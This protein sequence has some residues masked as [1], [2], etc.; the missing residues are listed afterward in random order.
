[1]MRSIGIP[2]RVAVGFTP[3]TDDGTGT[4][5]VRG[6]NAHAWPEVWFD[7][8]GWV[9][10]EPTPD[11]GAPGAED[12][13]GVAPQQAEGPIG[14]GES[15]GEGP[16]P[17]TTLPPQTTIAPDAGAVTPTTLA[18]D[19]P[20]PDRPPQTPDDGSVVPPT[21]AGFE[22]PW[23]V[24]LVLALI[25]SALVLPALIRRIRRSALSSPR[26][27]LAHLWIRALDAL[28]AMGLDASDARTPSETADVAG[29]IFP[30]ASR[31]MHSLADVVTIVNFAPD[32]SDR[33]DEPGQFG[34]TVIENCSQ[35]VRQVERAVSDSLGPAER[36]RR[37]FTHLN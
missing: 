28:R 33:L 2:A 31:P 23:R 12:Y 27:Q 5:S 37:Y 22:M 32:G 1:M 34:V 8:F 14:E 9:L 18:A 20:G 30:A 7:G 24:L 25:A 29:N 19:V 35:W 13:T 36:V 10:F 15:T 17:E 3:G 16:A 11:R 21:S 4:Y 6:R 26:A